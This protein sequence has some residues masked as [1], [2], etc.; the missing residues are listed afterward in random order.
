MGFKLVLFKP[1]DDK[2]G[3]KAIGDVFYD[4]LPSDCEVYLFYYGGA[5]PNEELTNRLKNFGN[6][7]G[8]NLFVNIGKLSD[9]NYRKVVNTFNIRTFPV[10]IMTATAKFA[11]PPANFST[12]YLKIETKRLLN[13]PD[14]AISCVEKLFNLFIEGKISEAIKEK[15]RDEL[16][17]RLKGTISDGLKEM[18]EFLDERDIN[19]SFI[20]GKLELKKSDG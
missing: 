5:T 19:F 14:L 15:N 3:E 13:S 1:E 9:P 2:T 12:T 7:T 4:N 6:I 8:K 18:R 17:A 11:S 16:V 20:E 10:I